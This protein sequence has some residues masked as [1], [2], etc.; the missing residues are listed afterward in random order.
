MSARKRI[1]VLGSTGS[2]G[3]STL[4]LLAQAEAC[5]SAEV[6]VIALS[7]GANVERLAEQALR[8]RPRVAVIAEPS[9]LGELEERLKGSGLAASAG[10]AAV[11]EAAEM[12]AEWVM[13]AI[14][15]SAGLAP[16]LAAARSGAVRWWTAG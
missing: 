3:A 1:T 2:V 11:V 8:W 14:V 7:A 16:T 15:G 9:L 12:G 13:S 5:G 6:E 10:S 4:D